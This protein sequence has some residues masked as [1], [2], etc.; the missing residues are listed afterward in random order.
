M[1]LVAYSRLDRREKRHPKAFPNAPSDIPVTQGNCYNCSSE[2]CAL[3]KTYHGLNNFTQFPSQEL[4]ARLL[5]AGPPSDICEHF[6][7]KR[8]RH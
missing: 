5:T 4:T 6:V 2:H 7:S 3:N 8:V 1:P